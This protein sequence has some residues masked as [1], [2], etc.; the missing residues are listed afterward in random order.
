MQCLLDAVT[1]L[2]IDIENGATTAS[3]TGCHLF[4][5]VFFLE[6]I[7]LG[8]FNMKHD[9]L[10][11]VK[12][13]DQDKLRRMATMATDVGVPEPSFASSMLRDPSTVCYSRSVRP[14][15]PRTEPK[16]MIRSYTHRPHTASCPSLPK[17]NVVNFQPGVAQT[18]DQAGCQGNHLPL[19]T[20]TT[21]QSDIQK[22]HHSHLLCFCGNKMLVRSGTSP[23]HAITSR[24]TW[25]PSR[26]SLCL[27]SQ[28]AALVA[29]PGSV[30]LPS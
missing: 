26:T 18:D 27:H 3:L 12:E 9:V 30:K 6:N 2:K 23:W 10:P 1:K 16:S 22:C 14:D 24:M 29:L 25:S 19:T 5:Q 17:I 8:F 7:D 20:P 28:P 21:L 4:L 15:E 13:F 11:R